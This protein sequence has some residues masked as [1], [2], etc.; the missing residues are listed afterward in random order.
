[1]LWH[2]HS[3]WL[4]TRASGSMISANDQAKV[5]FGDKAISDTHGPCYLEVHG[6]L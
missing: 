2:I 3:G 6:Q 4:N 5:K 1:M